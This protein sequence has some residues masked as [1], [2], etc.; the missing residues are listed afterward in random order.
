[1]SKRAALSII[2]SLRLKKE[3]NDFP[4]FLELGYDVEGAILVDRIK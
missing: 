1:M 3:I 4:T 2:L